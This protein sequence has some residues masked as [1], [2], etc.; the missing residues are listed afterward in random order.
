MKEASP[1][2]AKKEEPQKTMEL[3]SLPPV[4]VDPWKKTVDLVKKCQQC[5]R[6]SDLELGEIYYEELKPLFSKLS[7]EEKNTIY[8]LLVELQNQF[9]MLRFKKMKEHLK[10]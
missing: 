5:M 1:V 10:R 6:R 8:P 3:P 2:L 9:V 7:R 4:H